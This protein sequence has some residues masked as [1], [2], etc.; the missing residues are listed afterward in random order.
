MPGLIK[1][2]RKKHN[3]SRITQL[4]VPKILRGLGSDTA[5][6]VAVVNGK[7]YYYPFTKPKATGPTDQAKY[8]HALGYAD[9]VKKINQGA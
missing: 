3:R 9:A 1:V 4:K 6:D 7:V 5:V 8:L 2:K